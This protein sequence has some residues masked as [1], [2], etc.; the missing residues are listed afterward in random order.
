METVLDNFLNSDRSSV[1]LYEKEAF[2]KQVK[3]YG[4]SIV[5]FGAGNLGRKAL[6][7]LRRSGI[8]PL[9]F[10]DNNSS[11]W[12]NIVDGLKVF[13]P[14][15]AAERFGQGAAF[16]VTI[17]SPNSGHQ[18]AL[19]KK[20]LNDLSCKK[21][22]SFVSLTWKYSE[23]FLPN[24]FMDLPHKIH[25]NRD[26]L[27]KTFN[28]WED[29]LSRNTYITQLKWRILANYEK[30]PGKIDQPQ[31]F[32]EDIFDNSLNHVFIDCGAYDGDTVKHFLKKTNSSFSKIVAVEPDPF[33]FQ[34]LNMFVQ[35][36]PDKIKTKI[37]LIQKAVGQNEN[38]LRFA[39]LGTASSK[40]AS[41]GCIEVDCIT[42]DNMA[43]NLKP[44]FIKMDIE[45]AEIDALIGAKNIIVQN[46][47][48]LAICVYHK[49]DH[50]WQ[51]PLLIKS[52]SNQYRLFLRPH[53]EEGWDLVCY[54]VPENHIKV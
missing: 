20:K 36:L 12:N 53:D 21:V 29:E 18:Y 34:H 30:L 2:N 43:K 17:W 25:E 54:A 51:I 7:C 13:S 26:D 19:T 50:L 6:A 39:G 40:S 42:L 4:N 47:P 3:P 46:R 38:K 32:P 1:I 48:S 23:D 49:Q 27:I 45:G 14:N 31:Y 24:C 52:F 28:L 22:I 41:D 33:N 10:A 11:L 15:E 37:S 9:A 44:T 16:I 8:E 35:K 5:L